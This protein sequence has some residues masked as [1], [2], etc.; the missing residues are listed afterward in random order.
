MRVPPHSFPVGDD[1]IAS[2][3]RGRLGAVEICTGRGQGARYRPCSRER[4]LSHPLIEFPVN[5]RKHSALVSQ[6][7]GFVRSDDPRSVAVEADP[8]IGRDVVGAIT[9]LADQ[10]P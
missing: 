1:G 5:P 10:A 3:C 4:L 6:G 8:I 7:Q 9:L 2:I